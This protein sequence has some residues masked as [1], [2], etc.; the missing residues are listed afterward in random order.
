[1]HVHAS[2]VWTCAERDW[3]N[4]L[5]STGNT[6]RLELR[7]LNSWK[8]WSKPCLSYAYKIIP[9]MLQCIKLFFLLDFTDL[10]K[11]IGVS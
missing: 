3:T 5:R 9:V 4:Y 8:R 10:S 2:Q 1:M 6:H 11:L 7:P